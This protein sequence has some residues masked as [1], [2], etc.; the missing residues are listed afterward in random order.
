MKGILYDHGDQRRNSAKRISMAPTSDK[1]VTVPARRGIGGCLFSTW[2]PVAYFGV[3][4]L[5]YS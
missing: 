1:L 5:L 3:S 2:C 4:R